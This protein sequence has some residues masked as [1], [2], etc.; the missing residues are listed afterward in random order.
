MEGKDVAVQS[1]L[2]Q[3]PTKKSDEDPNATIKAVCLF[4]GIIVL[5]A[6]G[7]IVYDKFIAK[8][9]ETQCIEAVKDDKEA[10][11]EETDKGGK[12]GFWD[13]YGSGLFTL[14]VT[15]TGDVYL[16]VGDNEYNSGNVTYLPMTEFENGGEPGKYG[17]YTISDADIDNYVF[18]YEMDGDDEKAIRTHTFKGYKLDTN[19]VASCSFIQFGYQ[20]SGWTFA[21]I[22]DNGSV[23]LFGISP[24]L[25]GVINSRK[26][27]A[28]LSKN[29]GNYTNVAN[30]MRV[31]GEDGGFGLLF[32]MKDGS[33][34]LYEW[35]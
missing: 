35:E 2:V 21:F 31:S 30:V 14:Y 19:S 8:H 18:R 13:G 20:N 10:K 23:D 3:K 29:V 28:S 17:E 5:C 15:K 26:A 33:Q 25:K 1:E 34:V 11:K 22:K 6:A 16:E 7:Y 4:L 12:I 9:D 24:A 27:Y 32:V